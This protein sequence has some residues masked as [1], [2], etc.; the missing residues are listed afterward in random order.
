[1]KDI[2]ELI[3]ASSIGEALRDIEER[4]IDA[5]L[6][7]IEHEHRRKSNRRATTHPARG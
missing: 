7:S 1:M 4:G 2:R 5:H 3:A 6:K